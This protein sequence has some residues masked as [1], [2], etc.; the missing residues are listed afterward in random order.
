MH[1]PALTFW[2]SS[3]TSIPY[4]YVFHN[5]IETFYNWLSVFIDFFNRFDITN[6]ASS[7]LGGIGL[8]LHVV[9]GIQMIYVCLYYFIHWF[10]EL[11][12]SLSKSNICSSQMVR[13]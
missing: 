11:L 7:Y 2:L 3:K 5:A 1:G 4:T 9:E 12:S 6:N 10:C 13:V 8:W